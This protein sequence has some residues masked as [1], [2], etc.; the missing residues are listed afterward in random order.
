MAVLKILAIDDEPQLLLL[1]RSR[2]KSWGY[3]FSEARSGK[4]A[5]E[6]IVKEKPDIVV[7][8]YKMPD[9][10]GVSVLKKIRQLDK[11]LPVI[12]FTAYPETEV[13]KQTE[14]LGVSAFVPKLSA[15]QD[16]QSVLKS[17]IDLIGKNLKKSV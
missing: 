8:D 6:A 4:E 5:E 13:Q 9:M 15:Y 3:E 10:D 11:N 7:L 12:M 2:I 16:V 14:E 17:A 1:M